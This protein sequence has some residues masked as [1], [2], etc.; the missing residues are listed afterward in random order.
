MSGL[1]IE[2]IKVIVGGL[3][4]EQAP[5]AILLSDSQL[6][7]YYE[8]ALQNFKDFYQLEHKSAFEPPADFKQ[9]VMDH[10]RRYLDHNRMR[11]EI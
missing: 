5:K 3:L 7:N 11:T 4:L 10:V 6:E 2:T 9:L 8:P 1:S